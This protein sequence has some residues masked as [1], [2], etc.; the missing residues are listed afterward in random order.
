MHSKVVLV[1]DKKASV[2]TVNL[3]FRSF[4]LNFECGLYVY[5]HRQVMA[6]I[7]RDFEQSFA[8]SQRITLAGFRKYYPWY[9][10]AAGAVIAMIAPLL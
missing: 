6:D 10:R 8:Q 1:D 2:G 5:N 3:D 9:K 7:S 4:Y